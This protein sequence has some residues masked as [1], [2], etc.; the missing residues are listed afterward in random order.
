MIQEK[1]K[2]CIL[3]KRGQLVEVHIKDMEFPS[4]GIGELEGKK[5]YVKNALPGQRVSVR[6]KKNRREY[7]QGKLVEVINKA[8]Y[9]SEHFCTHFGLC[10]GCARQTVPYHMQ[11]KIKTDLVKKLIDD[12][13]IS[14]YEL[15]DTIKSPEIYG[16]RNKMEYTFGDESKG[17]EMTLG[18]HK[19]GQFNSV[20]TVNQC[21]LVDDDFNDILSKSLEYFTDRNIPHYINKIHKGY[22]RHL[23]VRKGLNTGEILIGLVTSTQ[24]K[25]DLA[26]YKEMLCSL[27]LKGEVKGII[28]IY[29][30]GLA[31]VVKCDHM[32]L[33][34]GQDYFDDELLGMRFKISPFSFFQT[35]TL[36]AE[37][38]YK[39]A[40]DFIDDADNKT[41]FD[42]Y[43]GTGTIGQIVAKK[44]KKVI[45]IEIVEEAVKAAN[46]NAKLNGLDNCKF[47]AG[48]VLEKIDELNEKPDI[49]VIDP[50]R[51]GVHPKA[52]SK[53]LHFAPKEILYVSCNPKTL[54]ENLKQI[55]EAGYK[56]ERVRCVDMFPHTPH[57]ETVTVLYRQDS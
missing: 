23:L 53:I 17:G 20:V 38:L 46:E 39:A 52:L 45:G 51:A 48:D 2:E 35:N 3:L 32:E 30:D 5:I 44:A 47:I 36:G 4:K 49:I 7:A 9:E 14:G 26:D 56:V 33:L 42:L 31:D 29:N 50:P 34:Y 37:A 1:S 10:G 24:L 15:L 19:R 41:I 12:A 27:G 6:I 22:L 57:V 40:L 43:S 55:H 11:L 28:H 54:A 8:P 18:M 25:V 21:K 13:G 16:Y